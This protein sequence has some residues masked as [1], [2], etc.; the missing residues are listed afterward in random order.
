MNVSFFSFCKVCSIKIYQ[1]PNRT[2]ITEKNWKVS[3]ECTMKKGQTW[4][5][6]PRCPTTQGE[7]WE[8]VSLKFIG[9]KNANNQKPVR[10][11]QGD[12]DQS[13]SSGNA[14]SW[15]PFSHVRSLNPKRS[16]TPE[17]GDGWG[18]HP[19]ET[20]ILKKHPNLCKCKL[21]KLTDPHSEKSNLQ[22]ENEAQMNTRNYAGHLL[23]QFLTVNRAP[24]D[25]N[26]HEYGAGCL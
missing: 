14:E 8:S 15:L 13:T 16:V 10:R 17:V 18:S 26:I 22:K 9:K 24:D 5:S 6:C 11:H 25:P 1:D 19:S 4:G 2:L 3:Q 20:I 12:A 23:R 7:K 21:E